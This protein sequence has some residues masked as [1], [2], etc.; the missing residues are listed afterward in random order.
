[1]QSNRFPVQ[2][3]IDVAM[4]ENAEEFLDFLEGDTDFDD[5]PTENYECAGEYEP[6][7][8]GF[9]FYYNDPALDGCP[10]CLIGDD[11]GVTLRRG[12]DYPLLLRF[13]KGKTVT[14]N[15][16]T[17]HGSIAMTFETYDTSCDWEWDRFTR[18]LIISVDYS[19]EDAS[20]KTY[21]SIFIGA[22]EPQETHHIEE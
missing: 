1:M 16:G 11:D 3:S 13:E 20:G 8:G 5:L 7:G 19:R 17:P 6:R 14:K 9:A 12:G 2:I 15:Y 4:T 21:H 10:T 18:D 22:L